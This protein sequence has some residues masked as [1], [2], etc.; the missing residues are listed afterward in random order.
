M[1]DEEGIAAVTDRHEP[2]ERLR[3][4]FQSLGETSRREPSAEELDQIWRAMSGELPAPERRALVE[5]MA[6]DPSLAEAWR[7]AHEVRRTAAAPSHAPVTRDTRTWMRP[8][9]AT[10]AVIFIAAALGALLQ[11]SRPADEDTFRDPGGYVVASLVPPDAALARDAFRLRWT[12]GPEDSRYHV[13]VTTED[14]RVLATVSD[15]VVPELLV[16]PDAL[17]DVA[18]GSR[19]LWQ[20][21]ATLPGGERV[22]SQ[23]F[24]ARVQ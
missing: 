14:L 23:T 1:S 21:E 10:A 7:V 20:V 5:R 24:V 3:K 9:L 8:G 2:D 19:V 17:S 15:L 13:R 12:G 4:A 16:N 11:L 18:S 22:S 6:G